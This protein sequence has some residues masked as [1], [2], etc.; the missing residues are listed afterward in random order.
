MRGDYF[1]RPR[2]PTK[3]DI[4]RLIGKTGRWA[5]AKLDRVCQLPEQVSK[6]DDDSYDDDN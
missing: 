5:F 6:F 1:D 4:G 2:L 3:D